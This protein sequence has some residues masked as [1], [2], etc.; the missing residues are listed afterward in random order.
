MLFKYKH[1]LEEL[2]KRGRRATAETVSIRGHLDEPLEDHVVA[3][4]EYVRGHVTEFAPDLLL[5][6]AATP[7]EAVHAALA[8]RSAA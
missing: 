3:A 1:L 6:F 7:A 8:G 2:R 4:V 5:V